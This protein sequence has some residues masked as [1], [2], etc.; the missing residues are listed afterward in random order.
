MQINL[1][2]LT[3]VNVYGDEAPQSVSKIVLAAMPDEKAG[4]VLKGWSMNYDL[5]RHGHCDVMR[6][7]VCSDAISD[8]APLP[9]RTAFSAAR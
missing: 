9:P 2:A 6:L 5:A 8:E 4:G 7:G 1:T 3:T